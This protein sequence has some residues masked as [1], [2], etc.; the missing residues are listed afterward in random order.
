MTLESEKD[1]NPMQTEAEART[2]TDSSSMKTRILQAATTLFAARG[3]DGVS[4]RDIT[5]I[6]GAKR[7][8]IIYHFGSKEAL[9]RETVTLILDRMNTVLHAYPEPSADCSDRER[10]SHCLRMYIEAFLANPEYAQIIVRE[11]GVSGERLDWI[12]ERFSELSER[13]LVEGPLGEK[14][15]STIVRDLIMSTLLGAAALRPYL[16]A[17]RGLV[18][19]PDW[20]EARKVELTELLTRLVADI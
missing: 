20:S 11:G 13:R 16:D 18:T 17:S 12:V 15:R 10:L 5:D 1:V 19:T 14:V 9:W 2:D 4:F 8:L 6:S 3:F 7:S